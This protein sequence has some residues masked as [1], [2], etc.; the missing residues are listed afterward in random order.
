MVHPDAKFHDGVKIT[1][2]DIA[3]TYQKF[4]DQGVPFYKELYKKVKSVVALDDKTARIE[5]NE[6]DKEGVV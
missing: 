6:A 3:F 4:W 1:A 5:M 2:N